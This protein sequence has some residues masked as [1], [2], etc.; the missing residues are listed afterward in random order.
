MIGVFLLTLAVAVTPHFEWVKFAD[1]GNHYALKEDGRQVGYYD[2]DTG[3]YRPYDRAGDKWLA[4]CPPPVDPP[5]RNFGVKISA[6]ETGTHY[7]RSG[8]ELSQEEADALIS[9][10]SPLAADAADKR[11]QVIII[12]ADDKT[13]PVVEAFNVNEE[14]KT[15]KQGYV[16]RAFRPDAWQVARTGYV[17]DGHP[18]IYLLDN[19]GKVLYRRDD[20][21]CGADGLADALRDADPDYKPENDPGPL[22]GVPSLNDPAIM[23]GLSVALS[24]VVAFLLFAWGYK[25]WRT[26]SSFSFRSR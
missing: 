4:A 19:G 21:D 3:V 10:T 5:F 18:T 15:L 7:R 2:G 23:I 8:V 20:F 13:R 22:F 11:L 26:S 6:T 25:R 1:G 24:A 17:C 14:L 12:G 16:V 9:G